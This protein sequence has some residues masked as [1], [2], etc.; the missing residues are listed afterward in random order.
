MFKVSKGIWQDLA[1]LER[2]YHSLELTNPCKTRYLGPIAA[3]RSG[4]QTL[5]ELI[6]IYHFWEP[7]IFYEIIIIIKNTL[8][9]KCWLV[10]YNVLF[11]LVL[12][13]DNCLRVRPF[14]NVHFDIWQQWKRLFWNGTTLLRARWII[15]CWTSS[16]ANLHLVLQVSYNR[17]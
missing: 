14:D 15:L 16:Y 1:D 9:F 11:S 17:K 10:K 8:F 4:N 12:P 3:S 6:R 2:T 7:Q 5:L 13:T